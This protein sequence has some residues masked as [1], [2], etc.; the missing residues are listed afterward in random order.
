MITRHHSEFVKL[1]N[2]LRAKVYRENGTLIHHHHHHHH[3]LYHKFV[4]NFCVPRSWKSVM[5]WMVF[6]E[7]LLSVSVLLT[8]LSFRSH[9]ITSLYVFIGCP[10]MKVR[11]LTLKVLLFPDDQTIVAIYPK[12]IPTHAINF[13][14]V[15]HSSAEILSS[16]PTLDIH[17]IVL[18][19]SVFSLIASFSLTEQVSLPYNI[20]L[21][22]HAEYNVTFALKEKPLLANK[23][24]KSLNL[25][26][27]LL[28]LVIALSTAPPVALIVLPNIDDI[29]LLKT[30][31]PVFPV[32]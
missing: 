5:G 15:L 26:Y 17:L 3:H 4:F 22:T 7:R 10:H 9:L 27:P 11:T 1:A 20:T 30:G 12:N 14:L 2:L 32:F 24:V 25:P 21:C 6:Y 29:F 23:G 31:I 16:G 18:A 13:S 28:I 8:F 19:S